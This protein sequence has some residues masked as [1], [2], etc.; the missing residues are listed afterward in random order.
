MT[1]SRKGTKIGL[2]LLSLLLAL[3]AFASGG[4]C[5]TGANYM[6]AS[7]NTLV[8]LSS[9]G[10]TSC[11]YVAASGSDSNSGTTE[12][13]P[14]LHAPQMPSCS[15]NCA[16]VQNQSGG[17]PAGT[18]IILRGGDVWHMGNSSAS[19]Y[20]GGTWNF[21]SGQYPMGSSSNPIYVGSDPSWYSGASWARPTL[22]GDNPP[23][24]NGNV[25]SGCT[26]NPSSD[27]S[28]GQESACTGLYYV[29]SCSYQM[30]GDGGQNIMIEL[31]G[32]K[33]YI[34]DNLELTG[35]CESQPGQAQGSNTYVRYGGLC[36][37]GCSGS[38]PAS[39][40]QNL[41]IHG[42]S[43]LQYAG[44]NGGPN[45]T[46][47][48]HCFNIFAFQGSAIGGALVGETLAYDVVDGA[49]SDPVGAGVCYGG[50]FNVEYS[51]FRYTSQCIGATHL[52]HDNLYEYFYEN[53]HS[54]MFEEVAGISGTNAIYNNV[55]R[56]VESGCPSD[57]L[58]GLWFDPPSGTTDYFFNNLYYD[59]GAI[60]LWIVG[61]NN[62]NAGTGIIFNNTVEFTNS[63]TQIT[64]SATHNS[65]TVNSA[66]NHFI[67]DNPSG[68]FAKSTF[69]SLTETTDL[70]MNHS[71]ATTDGYTSSET[72]PYSPTSASSPTVGTGT[73]E[74]ASN[75]AFCSALAD[76]GLSA[77]ATA[78]QS[79]TTYAC[80]Y[81]TTT[82]TVSCPARSV[83][84]RPTTAA[85]DIGAYEYNTQ[86]PPPAAPTGLT[87]V[88]Q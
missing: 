56:H 76:A 21:N 67:T 62:Q 37:S 5:P 73:N 31:S 48:T 79:D 83:T 59:E 38:A 54:N 57:C 15:S 44:Y 29:S 70:T 2:T 24:G 22:T 88:V 69:T 7:T 34:L 43:H 60:E 41:Y 4:T 36:N 68:P 25:G 84:A 61:Q 52:F 58:I 20:T 47:S 14:W 16:T 8:T 65:V 51:A 3:P 6:N 32:L 63:G 42:W 50:M 26:S 9:L 77:V 23:C 39:T 28:S 13:S 74:N 45:C 55:F 46:G 78:C 80:S 18:G 49:D 82:N 86:D 10:I 85:W 30:S 19:S 40:F 33:Y 66:N 27:C 1:V 12:T 64:G 17:I 75:G 35:L 53:G 11:Y 71:T 81:N 72:Y 87:A